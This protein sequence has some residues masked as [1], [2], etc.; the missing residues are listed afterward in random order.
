MDEIG[1]A[2]GVPCE[3]NEPLKFGEKTAAR[4]DIRWE[5]NPAS[6]ED[7]QERQAMQT[8]SVSKKSS[9][10]KNQQAAAAPAALAD[11]S[12]PKLGLAWSPKMNRVRA[13]LAQV[14]TG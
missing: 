6:S 1:E 5:L 13:D 3:D 8:E 2:V 7:Y 9:P 11:A 10:V 14:T 4:D 12:G